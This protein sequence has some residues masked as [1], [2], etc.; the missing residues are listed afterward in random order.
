MIYPTLLISALAFLLRKAI[1]KAVGGIR[2]KVVDAE[3]VVEERVEN[4]VPG[5]ASSQS[6][7][8]G[9]GEVLIEGVAAE[10]PGEVML[11][12]GGNVG[13]RDGGE[14]ELEVMDEESD[15]VDEGESE[16]LDEGGDGDSGE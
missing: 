13:D 4:Y 12:V 1:Y 5:E 7:G 16:I 15:E 11:E 9:E 8:D 10:T 2:Q 14:A 3:Y 6:Q